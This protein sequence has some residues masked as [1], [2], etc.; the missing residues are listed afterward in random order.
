MSRFLLPI[1]LARF[2]LTRHWEKDR[3]NLVIDVL[4][5]EEAYGELI[6]DSWVGFTRGSLLGLIG[7]QGGG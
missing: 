5:F 6:P 7:F 2:N 1:T 4:A 3:N